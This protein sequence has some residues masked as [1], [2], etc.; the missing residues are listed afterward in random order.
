MNQNAVVSSFGECA[1]PPTSSFAECATPPN[2]TWTE[3]GAGPPTLSSVAPSVETGTTATPVFLTGTGF[4]V[5]STTPAIAGAGVTVV[6]TSVIDDRTA[7]LLLTIAVGATIGARAV[8]VTTPY[9]TSNAS[10]LTITA[11]AVLPVAQQPV[12][13][14][15]ADYGIVDAPGAAL[16]AWGDRS[17]SAANT[18]TGPGMTA[19]TYR[20]T[21]FG[22]ATLPYIE[23]NNAHGIR[24]ALLAA[25]SMTSFTV[26]VVL[27][28]EV[29]DS[30]GLIYEH[31]AATYIAAGMHP[32]APSLY[33]AR[34]PVITLLES[35][36]NDSTGNW[37][38]TNT[39]KIFRHE[40]DG[41]NVGNKAYLNGVLQSFPTNALTSDPGTSATP[42][43][44][45]HIG[46]RD[47]GTPSLHLTGKVAALVAF[48]PKLSPTDTA[49]FEA[50]LGKWLLAGPA[51]PT[52]GH[53][54]I[55]LGASVIDGIT[56][57]V[58]YW[59]TTADPTADFESSDATGVMLLV[60][61][62]SSPIRK[63]AATQIQ[64]MSS[65]DRGAGRMLIACD[66]FAGGVVGGA[67]DVAVFSG[68]NSRDSVQYEAGFNTVV[69]RNTISGSLR[70]LTA[71]SAIDE[72]RFWLVGEPL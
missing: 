45:F 5:G 4:V 65:P 58:E 1:T 40:S 71:L 12:V 22:G 69:V 62:F 28:R 26:F 70:G 52:T 2:T 6:S 9:G 55:L 67:H 51:V 13:W 23:F 17:P 47:S 53:G 36:R 33:V 34:L 14:L 18:A 7:L 38:P 72:C 25:L 19:P 64:D 30:N 16:T 3:E 46:Y 54:P 31:H 43:G 11:P 49:A 61:H 24:T 66:T 50:Y 48:S 68:S 8:T 32:K 10:N 37:V 60:F 44:E 21:G 29:A 59:H 15:E 20:S 39:R 27:L 35:S 57:T 42:Q 41:T 56:V 63:F